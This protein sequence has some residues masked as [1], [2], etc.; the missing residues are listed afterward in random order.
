MRVLDH[1]RPIFAPITAMPMGFTAGRRGG[2]LLRARRR[3]DDRVDLDACVPSASTGIA[4]LEALDAGTTFTV[5]P[6]PPRRARRP[7]SGSSGARGTPSTASAARA[8][9]AGVE[10]A[11]R[12]ATERRPRS[13]RRRH[14]RA[15][16]SRSRSS[17][18]GTPR[19]PA[20][21]LRAAFAPQH[22]PR[23]RPACGTIDRDLGARVARP[24]DEHPPAAVR[25]AAAVVRGV[26]EVAR[27]RP[28]PVG[29]VRDVAAAGR[30]DDALAPDRAR[31]RPSTDATRRRRGRR[32]RRRRPGRARRARDGSRKRAGTRRRARA[33]ATCRRA[34][35]AVAAAVRESQRTRVETEAVVAGARRRRRRRA[36]APRRRAPA[37][38]ALPRWQPR[39]RRP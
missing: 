38:Q 37:V 35:D 28:R 33:T 18:L 12:D 17:W 11:E 26:H 24:D 14:R 3:R 13:G 27:E 6:S 4:V 31:R 9:R 32:A 23:S 19:V 21:D 16:C 20:D 36:P 8:V 29:Q 7:R 5:P 25:V 1:P 2:P 10:V 34:R 15:A 39:A 22:A 30:D